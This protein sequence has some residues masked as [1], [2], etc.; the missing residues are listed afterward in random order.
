MSMH[1][2]NNK[3]PGL[4]RISYEFYKATFNIIKHELLEVFQCQLDRNEIIE[5]NKKGVTRLIPKVMGVPKV[6][7]LRPITLLNCDYK[8]IAKWFVLRMKPTLPYVIKS[9]Q[10]CSVGDKKILF[11][12]SNILSRI[13]MIKEQ[14]SSGCLI[15][16]DFFKAYDRFFFGISA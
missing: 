13:A 16:L 12:V 5:S 1:S 9:G 11:G 7:Q 14:K 15:M 10:L 4:D 6:D 3:S 2:S 8:L